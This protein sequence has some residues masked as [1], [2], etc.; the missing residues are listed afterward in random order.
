MKGT[1]VSRAEADDGMLALGSQPDNNQRS[2][3]TVGSAVRVLHR[4]TQ[5]D[6]S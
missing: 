1:R 2:M 3:V 5:A 6:T 4:M